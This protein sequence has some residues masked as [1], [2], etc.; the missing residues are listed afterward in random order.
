MN[1]PAARLKTCRETCLLEHRSEDGR[2][3]AALIE[4]EDGDRAVV[5]RKARAGCD[6]RPAKTR[7]RRDVVT[8][9]VAGA[10]FLAAAKRA[11]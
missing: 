1:R 10:R 11:N 3:E 6:G 8:A 5:S 4:F 2:K 9:S 7:Q